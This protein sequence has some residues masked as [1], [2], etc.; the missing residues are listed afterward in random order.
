M[1]QIDEIIVLLTD[2]IG[3]D[4]DSI[5]KKSVEIAINTAMKNAGYLLLDDYLRNLHSND[6]IFAELIEEIKVPE[7]WFFRD[8]ESFNFIKSHFIN[9]KQNHVSKKIR[10][11]SIPCSTGEEPYSVM[12]TL[13]NLG[14]KPSD[15]SILG[16]D[17]SQQNIDF[18]TKAKYGKSS[19]RSEIY[20][21]KDKYFI[22][23]NGSFYLKE[24]YKNIVKF[25]KDNLIN[26]NFLEFEGEFDIIY[27]KNLFDLF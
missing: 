9:L 12:F 2:R 7:T 21:F 13:L 8:T 17:I 25:K 18:A 5:G 22:E 10:I 4:V 20:G 11:L 3:L 16:C 19:F 26:S 6:M 15:F 24:D 23:I 1:N 14:F 27:C